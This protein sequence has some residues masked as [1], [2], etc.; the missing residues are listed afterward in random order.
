MSVSSTSPTTSTGADTAVR[1]FR[2]EFAEEA[3]ADLRRRIEAWR[4]PEREPVDDQ[5]Q[6]VQ[7]ATVQ[8]LARYWATDYDW[9]GCETKLN[10]LPQF[11]TEIDG[12]D[13]HFIH[14]R[15][16][17]PDTL[18]LIVSHGWPGSVVEQLKIIEPLTNPARHGGGAADAFDVVIPSLPGYGFS[19]KPASAGWGPERIARAWAVL[20]ERL[21]YTGYVAQGGDWGTAV[22]AAMARQAPTGLLGIHV[23][24]AQMVPLEM[25]GHIRNGEPAPAGLSDAEKRAYGQVAFATYHRGYGVIQGTRPQ[26][27]GYSLADTPVGLAAWL[28]DHDTGTYE[29]LAR[30]FAG[31]PYGAI[32][33]QDW[34]DNTSLYWLTNTATSAARL[35]WQQ[36]VT[37]KNFYAPA[38]VSLPAAVTVFPEE[39]VHAPRS[40]TEQA[41]HDLIYFN[42]A[43]RGGHFA[44]WEQPQL[45]AEELRAAFRTLR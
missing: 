21:G 10:A 37:G 42:E 43:E 9:R 17:Q 16:G 5:S 24:F 29:H 32:T 20:M 6:G 40:W 27:I 15:S 19:G 39:Y 3:I 7:L 8:D 22:T 23:N 45:F 14:V 33:P 35:Y 13:I 41:Y 30:L 44:A 2:A 18:P 4:P 36:A 26:T 12:L 11:V 25:L 38:D 1:P 34:L 31:Q 28:M